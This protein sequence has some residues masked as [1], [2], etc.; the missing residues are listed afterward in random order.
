[1]KF[2]GFQPICWYSKTYKPTTSNQHFHGS[3]DST[4]KTRKR[5]ATFHANFWEADAAGEID[6]I[7]GMGNA[8]MWCSGGHP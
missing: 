1:M 4:S 8:N 7:G 6:P 3:K 5:K 2:Y